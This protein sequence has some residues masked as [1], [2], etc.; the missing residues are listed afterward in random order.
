M[1]NWMNTLRRSDQLCDVTLVVSNRQIR[2]HRILFA[3]IG[4]IVSEL[5]LSNQ[6]GPISSTHDGMDDNGYSVRWLSHAGTLPSF[7][8]YTNERGLV[9]EFPTVDFECMEALVNFVYSGRLIVPKAKVS[10]LYDLACLLHCDSVA[11]ICAEYLCA[12]LCIANCIS[13]RKCAN[14]FNDTLL[15]SL[16][17]QYIQDH[18]EAIIQ[19]S[20]EF[21]SLPHILVKIISDK[22]Q[23]IDWKLFNEKYMGDKLLEWFQQRVREL[24]AHMEFRMDILSEKPLA[25]YFDEEWNLHDCFEADDTSSV[26]SCDLVQEFKRSTQKLY[27]P[28]NGEG[29]TANSNGWKNCQNAASNGHYSNSSDW[30]EIEWKIVTFLN[31]MLLFF[32]DVT[33]T[34]IF[35]IKRQMAVITI[36]LVSHENARP[37]TPSFLS[38]SQGNLAE[39]GRVRL[40]RMATPRCA[41]GVVVAMDRLI[42]VGSISFVNW[43]GG[44]D[45]SADLASVEQWDPSNYGSWKFV[46]PLPSARSSMGVVTVNDCVYCIGGYDGRKV[47]NECL[48]YNPSNDA[49]TAVASLN[50]SRAEMACVTWKGRIYAIAGCDDWNK[51]YSVEYYSV[52]EDECSAKRYVLRIAQLILPYSREPKYADKLYV[53]G[54]TDG[55]QSLD[56]VECIDLNSKEAVWRPIPA[57]NSRRA[58]VRLVVFEDCLYAVGGFDGNMFLNSVEYLENG[59]APTKCPLVHMM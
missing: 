4:G 43:S 23:T 42:V 49:W 20:H 32:S 39:T 26:G 59:M 52:E 53:V 46:A 34:G 17:D 30:E 2:G 41:G 54:G 33:F 45:G 37:R 16:V 38:M 10:G 1:V 5:L 35:L 22:G 6:R 58:N 24:P 27:C 11:R 8:L 29:N 3:T 14:R 21:S 36:E 7:K 25:C 15:A 13:T 48:K 9:L 18:F 19:E 44:M 12:N 28:S 31:N 50:A 55:V 57:M 40:A 51:L 47:L 56:S